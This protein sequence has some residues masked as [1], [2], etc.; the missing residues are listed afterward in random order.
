MNNPYQTKKQGAR[1]SLDAFA[2]RISSNCALPRCRLTG[3]SPTV[4]CEG[5]NEA[6]HMLSPHDS[7]LRTSVEST[8]ASSPQPNSVRRTDAQ[9]SWFVGQVALPNRG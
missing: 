7:E 3:E 8:E 1:D 9:G 4:S 6:R 2:L 5:V